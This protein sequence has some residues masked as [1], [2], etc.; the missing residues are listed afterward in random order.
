MFNYTLQ[1]IKRAKKK[2]I[3]IAVNAYSHLEIIQV[4]NII[5]HKI[6]ITKL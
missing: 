2:T 6:Q 4:G 1:I 3:I 5:F